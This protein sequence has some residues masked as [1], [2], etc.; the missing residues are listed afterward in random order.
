M[1]YTYAIPKEIAFSDCDINGMVKLT[2]LLCWFEDH[3]FSM[4][5]VAGL[6]NFLPS[7]QRIDTT[8]EQIENPL[9]EQFLMPVL[10]FRYCE[11]RKIRFGESILLHTHM[12]K[13]DSGQI[14]FLQLVTNPLGK[15]IYF[16]AEYTIGIVGTKIG[17][18]Y[19]IPE[20]MRKQINVFLYQLQDE[21]KGFPL[22]IE[23][24]YESIL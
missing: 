10:K 21:K 1:I 13:P 8:R 9:G 23:G 3:R 15:Q 14:V 2:Q 19:E 11:K 18:N 22:E 6:Q 20:V 5:E 4:T 16:I 12:H 17:L 24:D 7:T